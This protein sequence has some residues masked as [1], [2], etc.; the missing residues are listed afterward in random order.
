MNVMQMYGNHLRTDASRRRFLKYTGTPSI[1]CLMG[2]AGGEASGN[3]LELPHGV[4]VGDV[5]HRSA[6]FWARTTS[7]GTIHVEYSPERSFEDA[8]HATAQVDGETDHVRQIR[9]DDLQPGT[10]YHY[11]GWATNGTVTRSTAPENLSA[12][13]LG[14]FCTAPIPDAAAAVTLA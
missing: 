4:A 10:R 9:L 8:R 7:S 11:R 14:T 6:V 5:T 12:V 1:V 2:D 13:E 3:L